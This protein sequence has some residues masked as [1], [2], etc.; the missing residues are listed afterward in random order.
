M[1]MLPLLPTRVL[2][3]LNEQKLIRGQT[4]ISS[5][6]LLGPLLQQGGVKTSKY[7][8]LAHSPTGASWFLIWG[9]DRGVSRGPAGGL[10]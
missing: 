9:E 6:A 5:K 2:G 4:R 7:P 10:A 3:L 1:F 8:L